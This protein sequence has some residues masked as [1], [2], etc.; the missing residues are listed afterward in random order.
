MDMPSELLT[1]P[2][3]N[4]QLPAPAGSAP[5]VCPRCGET[6]LMQRDS[7]YE[8]RI[9]PPGMSPEQL[10]ATDPTTN[11]NGSA[12]L[13]QLVIAS[14]V[15]AVT[16]LGLK[17]GLPAN[18]TAQ[19]AFPFMVLLSGIGLVASLWLWFFRKKRPNFAIGFF[20]LANMLIVALMAL[21]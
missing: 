7:P 13:A 1:C 21:P 10:T 4:T 18:N 2:F 20:V 19:R 17:L 5:S 9:M 11:G 8:Q 3:C 12:W 6:L 15:L 14:A 16:S